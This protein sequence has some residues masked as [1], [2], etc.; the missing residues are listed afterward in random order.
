MCSRPHPVAER[1]FLRAFETNIGDEGLVPG[2]AE[3]EREAC[4]L[5]GTW[6]GNPQASGRIVTGGTEANLL[7]LWT[8]KLL[9]PGKCEVLLPASAH[10]SFDK[11]ASFM[12]LTLVRVPVDERGKVRLDRFEAAITPLTMAMIG[13]AGTT[14]WGAVDDIGALASLAHRR[15]LYFHLDASF[16]GFVLPFL[17]ENGTQGLYAWPQG[18]SSLTADPHK[19]GRGPIPSGMI[20]WKDA[21]LARTAATD[22]QYLSG[23]RL[24]QNTLVG[25]RS[26][27]AVAGVWAVM[28]HLGVPGYS[29][30]VAQAMELSRFLTQAL[31]QIP[32]VEPVLPEPEVNVVGVRSTH[33][34]TPLLVASLREKGWAL[35]TWQHSFRIVVMPHVTRPV[36]KEFLADLQEVAG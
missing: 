8:A 24:R 30:I 12:G 7:A 6:W 10:Y 17:P 15:G 31:T 36:L 21:T 27:A 11:A 29:E 19:M 26:G 2:L 22:V 9:S 28:K 32:G 14:A 13:I 25:T 33:M 5:L 16:G 20:L 18:L 23:G 4:T 3:L 35:S 1:A 34:P